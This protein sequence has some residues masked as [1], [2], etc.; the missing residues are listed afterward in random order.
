MAA[1]DDDAVR[2]WD[3]ATGRERA[4]PMTGYYR[5]TF[6]PDGKILAFAGADGTIR[7]LD[8]GTWETIA[9][10][11]G[12]AAIIVWRAAHTAPPITGL[13][14]SPDGQML[15]SAGTDLTVRLWHLATKREVA[16]L[17]GHT[18]SIWTLA[19][20]PDGKTVATCS[21]DGTVKL[22]N[23]AVQ[24]EAATLKG[25]R[26][27]VA[28]LAFAPDG[29]MLAIAGADGTIRLWRASAFAET[30]RPGNNLLAEPQPERPSA[31]LE[32]GFLRDWL[33]LAPIPLAGGQT[34]AAAV[35]QRLVQGEAN[36]QPRAGDPVTAGTK[37]L[38]WKEH[39]GQGPFLDFNAFLG[40][41]TKYSVAYAVC[42]IVC[43]RERRDL[44]MRIGSDDQAKV[45]LNGKKV[46]T[47]HGVRPCS[48]DDDIVEGITLKR[49]VNVLLFKV[50][51]EEGTWKGC[52]RF[53]DREGNPVPGLQVRLAPE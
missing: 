5:P 30:D 33:V 44:E 51:N 18:D 37:E 46:Y 14:F 40:K 8:P 27:Q 11:P 23:L 47:Y 17:K 25:H 13:A 41:E 36:L 45:Y 15:A 49:G 52:L 20:A 48:V 12:H 39:R 2:L 22:W 9:T 34:G 42:Y 43:D 29:T 24:A 38:V 6:S 21:R 31:A 28:A 53:V 16:C 1:T 7:L 26:G 10:L 3:I 32:K 19:F 50:V 4:I 35:E